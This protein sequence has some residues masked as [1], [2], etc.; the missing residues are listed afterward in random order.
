MRRGFRRAGSS[1]F[2]TLGFFSILNVSSKPESSFPNPLSR[3]AS[4]YSL[5]RHYDSDGR[6]LRG[7]P[8]FPPY[9]SAK[10]RPGTPSGSAPSQALQPCYDRPDQLRE[11]FER[12]LVRL[13]RMA[14]AIHRRFGRTPPAII[15]S[16]PWW[17][18]SWR[19]RTS[20]KPSSFIKP[21]PSPKDR[22]K[23]GRHPILGSRASWQSA[24]PLRRCP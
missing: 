23:S 22:W 18:P 1:P 24:C 12:I 3:N 16:P 11:E 2:T 10:S 4:A 7:R 9:S 21:S 15:D 13:P 20:T 14:Q 19:K 8:R 17:L 5:W 6:G